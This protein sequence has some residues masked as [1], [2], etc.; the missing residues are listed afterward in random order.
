MHKLWLWFF[1]FLAA[2]FGAWLYP[3]LD[4]LKPDAN[5][6]LPRPPHLTIQPF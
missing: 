6:H 2:A 3:V 4:E 1:V 5:Q